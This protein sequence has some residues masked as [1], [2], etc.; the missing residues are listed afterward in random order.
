MVLFLRVCIYVHLSLWQKNKKF[1]TH[2]CLLPP[3]QLLHTLK[4]SS[5]A[6]T[7]SLGKDSEYNSVC[8]N[9]PAV[10]SCTVA[11]MQFVSLHLYLNDSL[12]SHTVHCISLFYSSPLFSLLSCLAIQLII[13][14]YTFLSC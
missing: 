11:V 9:G 8:K 5:I 3:E 13:P 12:L 7:G 1:T 4:Q 2:A 6:P 14:F 10:S